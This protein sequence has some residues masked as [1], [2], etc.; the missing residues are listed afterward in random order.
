MQNVIIPMAGKGHRFI[1][2]GYKTYKPFL[3]LSKKENIIQNICNSFPKN[4]KKIFI[5]DKKLNNN[6]LKILKQIPNSKII[7]VKSHKLGPGYTLLLAKKELQDL[8][9]IFVSYSDIVW[10]WN[11]KKLNLKNNTVFCYKNYHPYTKDNNNYAF[12]KVKNNNLIKLKEKSSFTNNWINEPLSIGLF[13]YI[14]SKDLF[15]SLDV[16]KKQNI[17]TNNEYFPSEG[18][19]FLK[20]SKIEYVDTFAHIGKPNYYEEFKDRK[21][22]FLKR[23]KFINSIKNFYLADKIVIPAAGNSVRFK[24]EKIFTPKHLYFIKEL[25][26]KLLDYIN[27]YLPKIRKNLVTFKN[28]LVNELSSKKY[29][30]HF[31]DNATKGQADTIFKQLKDF[32]TNESFFINS[33][34]VFS[35][36][37]FKKYSKLIKKSDIIVF[38]S[39]KSFENLPSNS[40]T[41]VEFTKNRFKNVFIKNKP[42]K[43]LKILTGNFYFKNKIIYNNCFSYFFR[44]K[45]NEIFIDDLIK[46]SIKLK[47]N[48]GVIEDESYINLGTPDLIKDFI[49]WKNFFRN[50]YK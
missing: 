14:N 7:K 16:L 35:T 43:K 40:Y 26:F 32:K 5:I 22:F 37:D 47:Y 1:K 31:L 6:Y 28:K 27:I 46:V 25:N 30:I 9:K 4:T 11:N 34:D 24:K 19:N 21:N 41:W 3:P 13:Y 12:C 18:F 38:V 23:K 50:K 49:F 8:K 20:N 44:K 45:F 10:K 17:K 33:C 15:N 36:F 2:A 48:V 29:K 42:K 39:N